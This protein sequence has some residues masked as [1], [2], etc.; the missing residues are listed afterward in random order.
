MDDIERYDF[1]YREMEPINKEVSIIKSLNKVI[2]KYIYVRERCMS[3]YG[4]SPHQIRYLNFRINSFI[5]LIDEHE[6]KLAKLV[7]I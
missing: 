1:W 2:D 7:T 4:N 5:K 3:D 6:I